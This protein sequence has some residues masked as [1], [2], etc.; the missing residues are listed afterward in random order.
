VAIPHARLLLRHLLEREGVRVEEAAGSSEALQKSRLHSEASNAGE[1]IARAR[2]RIKARQL[3]R[4]C[5]VHHLSAEHW[6]ERLVLRQKIGDDLNHSTIAERVEV[7]VVAE[8]ELLTL[9][10]ARAERGR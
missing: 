4:H 7:D 9:L 5:H 10:S 6:A 3:E 8:E 1:W 2:G